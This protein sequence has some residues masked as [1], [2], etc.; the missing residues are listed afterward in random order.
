MNN[1]NKNDIQ[2]KNKISTA[3]KL[4]DQYNVSPIT[5]KHEYKSAELI[6]A[7]GESYPEAK[8]K[9]VIVIPKRYS[10]KQPSPLK[11][12]KKYYENLHFMSCV[13]RLSDI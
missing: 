12:C 10:L 7:I 1:I 2:P 13:F 6:D 9:A 5:I 3:K 8:Q 4:A 11:K